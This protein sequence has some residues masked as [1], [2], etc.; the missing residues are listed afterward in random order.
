M[1]QF[2]VNI[3]GS[4]EQDK[5][6]VCDRTLNIQGELY[7]IEDLRT[8]MRLN[9]NDEASF[10]IYKNSNGEENPLWNKI[11][12]IQ[13]ILVEGKGYFEIASPLTVE[14]CAYKQVTGISL[15]EA[16]A[17]Q[18][19]ITLEIN[20]DD[21]IARD[22]YVATTLYNPQNHEGSLLHR[23]FKS[24]PHYTVGHVDSSIACIQRTFSC[25]NQTVYNFLQTIAGE[26]EC[27]FVFDNYA[28]VV[29]CYDLK[30]HC[31]RASCIQSG[32]YRDVENGICQ[33]CHSSDYV[34]YGYGKDTGIF[35]DGY[36]LT[37]S[38]TLTG[39][40]DSVKNCFK[41]EGAD[42]TIT[43]L[44]GDRLMDGNYIWKFSEYQIAQ[45]SPTL[46]QALIEHDTLVNSYQ[47]N[48]NALWDRYNENVDKALHYQSGMMPSKD[49]GETTA[50]SVYNEISRKITYVC[51]TSQY[52]SADSILKSINSFAKVIAP[53][54]YTVELTLINSN[55]SSISFS[56]HIFLKD[57]YEEDN[58]TLKDEYTGTK[59]IPIKNV[60]GDN[61]YSSTST[62]DKPVFTNDYFMYL[63]QQL[64]MELE[65]NDVTEEAI[66]FNPPILNNISAYDPNTYAE[67]DNETNP[68]NLSS[69]H[70]TMYCINRLQSFRDAYESCSQIIAKLNSGIASDADKVINTIEGGLSDYYT[71]NT[72]TILK[73]I[74][75][76]GTTSGIYNDL[77]GRYYKYIQCIDA[78]S[79]YLE[80]KVSTLNRQMESYKKQ[81]EEIKNACNMENFLKKYKN[82]IYGD[83]LWTELC[84]FKRED[85]YR[86]DNYAAEGYDN[87]TVI[88]NIEGLI[89]R[90]K[91]VSADACEIHYSIN[92]TIGN[93][94]T[95]DEF[96][97][98]WGDFTIGNWLRINI[99]GAIYKLRLISVSFDYTDVSH[100]TVEFSDISNTNSVTEDLKSIFQQA[101]SIASNFNS[102]ARQAENGD[103]TN[104][105]FK[106]MKEAGLNVANTMITNADNQDFIINQYGLTG[107][108]WNDVKNAYDDE[109][110]RI[111]N[112]LF[113][114]TSDSW[115]HTRLALG[116]IFFYNDEAGEW[117]WAYG[118]NA[119]V[120]IA[121]LIM[122]E[123]LKIYNKSGTYSITDKGFFINYKD[124][125]IEINAMEPSLTIS[126]MENGNKHIYMRYSPADGL[127]IDG[128]GRFSGFV[129][130]GNEAGKHIKLDPKNPSMVINDGTENI[131]DFNSDG[132]GKLTIRKGIITSI[133]QSLDYIPRY[134]G[135]CINL[136]EKF[137]EIYNN[138]H[139]ELLSFNL[140][141]NNLLRI[142]SW[143]IG[144]DRIYSST[145]LSGG[146]IRHMELVSDGNMY[147]YMSGTGD[148]MQN[149]AA[150]LLDGK[151]IFGLYDDSIHDFV[152]N[153]GYI[154]IS[155]AGLYAASKPAQEAGEIRYLLKVD[156]INDKVE[157]TNSS[158]NCALKIENRGW[159][160]SVEI[161]N[162]SVM[163]AV[164]VQNHGLGSSMEIENNSNKPALKV[165]N[166]GNGDA[167]Y[168][169]NST[170]NSQNSAFRARIF[171]NDNLPHYI[172]M[173]SDRF[174]NSGTGR[175]I[176]RAD[177]EEHWVQG[178]Y[179]PCE[180]GCLGTTNYPWSEAHIENVVSTSDL[181]KKEIIGIIDKQ[182]A[183]G[184]TLALKPLEF[185]FKSS[186]SKRIHMGFGAQ[187]VA[188]TA[189]D[190]AMGDLAIYEASVRGKEGE[191]YYK[192]GIDDS[193]LA[194][195]LKYNEFE[196]PIVASIQA[197]HEIITEQKKTVEEQGTTIKNQ[198]KKIDDLTQRIEKLEKIILNNG[199][200]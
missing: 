165:I 50:L 92:T 31:S 84:S 95:M 33:H 112:N 57:A 21:D 56:V 102:V 14:E 161:E 4:V 63:K 153:H 98:L 117:Q 40:K 142:G 104:Q 103:M 75:S 116:K 71:G 139:E 160:G 109:Q 9:Q 183:L 58:I 155:Q 97:P 76:S 47:D 81:I 86:N 170:I 29:N 167:I 140:D 126:K 150:R 64:E 171:T 193:K 8:T 121:N 45:M 118:L 42:D 24:M 87:A 134:Q 105:E 35:L 39:D 26:L 51:K 181:K 36:N 111:I 85:V 1:S 189:K 11:D 166:H 65:K 198:N 27:I 12:D 107:R 179:Q 74:T 113:C 136:E 77:L 164:K 53:R 15:G 135:M 156:T 149:Y 152:E 163:S 67:Y 28:R 34:S 194:W 61:I 62:K 73:Y 188:Q 19:N 23:I 137:I 20:T 83:S 199:L 2:V 59:T 132:S 37:E 141:K 6:F 70:Y 154:D 43:N 18:T 191:E 89:K 129:L 124:N 127:V 144:K 54:T 119:E 158:Q 100:I 78:R 66:S 174:S 184:F 187:H 16:E 125:T 131:F 48:Y 195:G 30:D 180:S 13:I 178:Q 145:A 79:S 143:N 5:V 90:A 38:I 157:I 182:K 173:F 192:D 101:S 114:F 91:E 32:E 52:Q 115:G 200:S 93:L 108:I 147:S 168:C 196:A 177:N 80:D 122:S 159:G 175:V 22:G 106:I 151:Y 197:L 68:Q 146:G 120:L 10:K 17:S 110:I 82:G 169:E 130:V 69:I 162:T 46:R 176:L 185:T 94:L 7:P 186:T 99:D 123:M 60:Y 172:S 128:T 25:D 49:D 138:A 72:S 190:L 44:L 96:E 3:D 88:E 41:I 55:N 133:L 148:L